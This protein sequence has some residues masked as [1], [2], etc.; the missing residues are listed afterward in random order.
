MSCKNSYVKQIFLKK[1]LLSKIV[2][3]LIIMD[4]ALKMC[5]KFENFQKR[6]FYIY[7]LV[8]GKTEFIYVVKFWSIPKNIFQHRVLFHDIKKL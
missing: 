2:F 1:K 3:R 4:T 8:I 7:F 6:W 5:I